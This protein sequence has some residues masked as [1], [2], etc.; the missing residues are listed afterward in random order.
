[1][2]GALE[3]AWAVARVGERAVPPQPAPRSLRP[4]L[5]HARLTAA[6]LAT[7]RKAVDDD[8]EFRARV[9]E[10]VDEEAVGRAGWLFLARPDG[11]EDE[12]AGL[13]AASASATAAEEEGRAERSAARRL[14]G[15]EEARRRVEEA[16][17]EE[18]A[19]AARTADELARERAARR[20]AEQALERLQREAERLRR[21]VAILEEQAAVTAA[22]AAAGATAAASEPVVVEVAVPTVP[23]EVVDLVAQAAEATRTAQERLSDAMGALVRATGPSPPEERD[24]PGARGSR[25]VARPAPPRRQ[26]AA[27]PPAVFEDSVEAADH[28]VRRPGA[29]LLVDGYN[30][31]MGYRPDLPIAELRRRLVDAVDELVART[32]VDAQVVFDGADTAEPGPS[33]R[34]G[35]R[36]LAARVAFSPPD[37]EADDVI[38]GLVDAAPLSRPVIVA[39]DDRQVQDGARLRGASVISITQ[40]LGVLRRER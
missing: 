15:A 19:Q 30:A 1:V 5:G 14:K 3:A 29:V 8:A 9:A 18:R 13:V 20:T 23:R 17:A 28:L 21:Q 22:D 34:T 39:S 6:A 40:L 2:R 10:A 33:T 24:R 25:A 36:R 11:W 37:V 26:P 31:S 12:V 4:L 35:G 16:L 32:G 38:L 27:L 7:I